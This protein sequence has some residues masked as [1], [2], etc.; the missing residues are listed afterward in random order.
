MKDYSSEGSY[1]LVPQSEIQ[2]S[3]GGNRGNDPMG[4]PIPYIIEFRDFVRP[5]PGSAHAYPRS[6]I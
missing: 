1:R 3:E 6:R 5:R 4:N 2:S